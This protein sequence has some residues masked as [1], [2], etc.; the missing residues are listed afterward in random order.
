M[1][2]RSMKNQGPKHIRTSGACKACR[3]RKQKCSGDRPQ[4]VRCRI[5][6]VQCQWPQP[7]KRGPPK[8]Y[9]AIIEKRLIETEAILLALMS[10]VSDEQL[11]SA[12]NHLQQDKQS[13]A[14]LG[15][16]SNSGNRHE[17]TR[18]DKFG[19]V[20]W[21]NYTLSSA[22]DAR[23]WWADRVSA[24]EHGTPSRQY[25]DIEPALR[26]T[27]VT[28]ES[29]TTTIQDADTSVLMSNEL[30]PGVESPI[31]PR[32]SVEQQDDCDARVNEGL[33]AESTSSMNRDEGT[34][35]SQMTHLEQT[36]TWSTG[37][38]NSRDMGGYE[39]AYLW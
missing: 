4:C 5:N 13:S 38:Q 33:S 16:P 3:S 17:L 27:N 6:E 7:Q 35:H 37:Y 24:A 11:M 31:A 29:E 2:E 14:N 34:S 36:P 39:S 20:Y 21:S 15:V 28:S 10:Q 22:Q 26:E 1:T 25:E 19:P 32:L 12:Y 9:T 23:R 18:K 30:S 8:H